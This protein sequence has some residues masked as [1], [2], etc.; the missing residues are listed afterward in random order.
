MLTNLFIW[1]VLTLIPLIPTVLLFWLFENFAYFI[2]TSKGIKMGGSIAAYFILLGFAF[3]SWHYL[4]QDQTVD[5]NASLRTE[6]AGYWDCNANYT[7]DNQTINSSSTLEIVDG[8]YLTIH[9]IT[10]LGSS[11]TADEVL[12]QP[13]KMTFV[14]NVQLKNSIGLT[15]VRFI[16]DAKEITGFYGIWGSIGSQYKGNIFCERSE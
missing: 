9:G 13:N 8:K 1:G 14:Y 16:R 15:S 3:G 5:N 2:N 10:E 6:L 7:Q 4:I 11:W 12:L